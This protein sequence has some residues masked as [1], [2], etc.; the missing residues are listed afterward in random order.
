LGEAELAGLLAG[1]DWQ[2]L[3][4][5]R[6]KLIDYL[7]YYF[8][9]GGMPEC[10]DSF[11]AG[12][13]LDKVRGIQ[14]RLLSAYEQDFSKYAEPALVP[15]IRAESWLTNIPFTRWRLSQRDDPNRDSVHPGHRRG[16]QRT[17]RPGL[18]IISIFERDPRESHVRIIICVS[19]IRV[20]AL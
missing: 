15:R 2:M 4:L 18:F 19:G 5:F 13:D 6:D 14:R 12:R 3:E 20:A 8:C 17:S 9:V 10:V 11:V 1:H 16:A 7:K